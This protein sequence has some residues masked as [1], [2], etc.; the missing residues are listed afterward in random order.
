M[1]AKIDIQMDKVGADRPDPV[2][3]IEGMDV[4]IELDLGKHQGLLEQAKLSLIAFRKG[5]SHAIKKK[6]HY[7]KL[8]G[9]DKFDDKALKASMTMIATDI[10]HL[11]DKADTAKRSIEHHT[12][13][14]DTLTEQLA[15]YREQLKAGNGISNRLLQ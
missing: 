12:L 5:R 11:S 4:I 14:V 10:R 8:I 15:A 2:I 9:G 13:I 6:K 7:A 1:E 3:V